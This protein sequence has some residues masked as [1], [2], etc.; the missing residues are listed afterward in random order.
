M[1]DPTPRSEKLLEPEDPAVRQPILVKRIRSTE[2]GLEQGARQI[3][4]A[5]GTM[6]ALLRDSRQRLNER[7][8]WKITNPLSDLRTTARG[9][10]QEIRHAAALHAQEWRRAALERTSG[11][12]PAELA[13]LRALGRPKKSRSKL[14]RPMLVAAAVLGLLLGAGLKAWRA[15]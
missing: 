12:E 13:L 2:S 11:P 3:G 15:R 1:D 4:T 14:V 6:V 9:H 10:A 5:L 8:P 7:D